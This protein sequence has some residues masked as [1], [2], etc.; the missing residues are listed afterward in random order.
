[1]SGRHNAWRAAKE[2][3]WS[4]MEIEEPRTKNEDAPRSRSFCVLES[5]VPERGLEPRTWRL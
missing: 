4:I 3:S 2:R 1:V 5:V